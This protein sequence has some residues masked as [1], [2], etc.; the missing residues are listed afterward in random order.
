MEAG[1]DGIE[2]HAA[3]SY[4]LNQFL[5][6]GSN[7]RTD[8]YGGNL[9]NRC[10][11]LFEVVSAVK[12]SIGAE[13]LG[14]RLSPLGTASGMHDSDPIALY[15]FVISELSK[16]GIAYLHMIEARASVSA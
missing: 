11:L 4:L 3:N 5:E 15:T 16:L 7:Q 9:E 8:K 2:L 14:V 10:R 6:D 12:D 13:R 1:F